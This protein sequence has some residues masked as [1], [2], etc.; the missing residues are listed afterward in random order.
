MKTFVIGDIHGAY[1]ALLQ[2][3][4]RSGFNYEN[5]RLIVLGDVCDGWPQV[6]E[7]IDELLKVKNLV[8]ILG[9]HD[10]WALDW[11]RDGRR[12]RIWLQQGG[13]N[14]IRSYGGEMMLDAHVE[15][16]A[17]AKLYFEENLRLFVHAGFD[18]NVA[19]EEQDPDIFLWDRQ[20]IMEAFKKKNRDPHG[21]FGHF[22][23]IFIGHTPTL[24]FYIDKPL[25]LC[26]VWALDTGAG[27]DGGRLTIMNL[28][29]KEFWQSDQS[30]FLYPGEHGRSK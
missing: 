16:L 12:E 28:D 10:Q 5:D 15:F 30:Q 1:R 7:C 6:K 4:E 25:H 8:Y 3:F 29:T 20:L 27:W 2:C 21:H 26:N 23:E 18:P 14:T 19:L 9:N 22:H 13:E 11:G 24:N 17:E